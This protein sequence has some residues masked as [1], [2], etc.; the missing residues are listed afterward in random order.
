MYSE[1]VRHGNGRGKDMKQAVTTTTKAVKYKS[2][3][4]AALH[5]TAQGLHDIGILSDTDMA[6]YNTS[7]IQ[8]VPW[9]VSSVEA[10]DNYK[11]H[12]RFRDGLEGFVEMAELVLSPEARVFAPLADPNQ[13]NKVFLY[14]EAV[15]WDPESTKDPFKF[16]DLAPDA[17]YEEIKR[18]GRWILM[19]F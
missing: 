16:I 6:R 5:E 2:E 1:R 14:L 11:L 19:V 13:F 12:V 3:A 7:C 8:Q 9:R 10:L 18:D 17:M 15:S 4:L